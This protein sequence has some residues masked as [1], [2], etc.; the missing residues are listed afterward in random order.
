MTL[1]QFIDAHNGKP[2]E[3]EDPSN[4][5]QC[6]DLAFGWCDN[7]K[8]PRE[9]IRHL[10]AYQAFTAPNDITRQ[11]FD[12]IAFNKNAPSRG[13]L[14]IWGSGV[15]S[16]G[17]FAVAV[18][19]DTSSFTSFDQNWDTANYHTPSGEPYC[20]LVK[21]NYNY[22]IGWLHPKGGTNLDYKA[23]YELLKRERDTVTYPRINLLENERDT[24][25]YPTI[26]KQKA[27]IADLTKENQTLKQ[28]VG[29]VPTE[30]KPG[31]YRVP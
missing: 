14:V 19:A 21:H 11:Y 27:Q 4:R 9:T 20:R 29:T 23:E 26:E 24:V 18:S 5:D 10:Y 13:D 7:L 16:A 28:Q 31:L 3:V 12:L 6:M 25:L 22:I 15:G 17:H 8:I 2:L 1:E 30:L